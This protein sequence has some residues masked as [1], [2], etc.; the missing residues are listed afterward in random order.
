MDGKNQNDEAFK[1]GVDNAILSCMAMCRLVYLHG[2]E[3]GF[4]E[5]QAMLLAT[6]YMNGILCSGGKASGKNKGTDLP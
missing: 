4:N 5:N 1:D 3:V 2:K 6:C